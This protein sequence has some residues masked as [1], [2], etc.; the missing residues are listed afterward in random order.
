MSW[1]RKLLGLC[2][3]KWIVYESGD[4]Y[5]DESSQKPRGSYYVLQCEHCGI[6]QKHK[7]Y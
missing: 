6:L 3:H 4:I 5:R 7:F 1:W 2:Q